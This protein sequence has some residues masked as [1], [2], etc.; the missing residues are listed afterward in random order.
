[1][2]SRLERLLQRPEAEGPVLFMYVFT[3][4]PLLS[5]TA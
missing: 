2:K 1:M 4:Y 5:V 3:G